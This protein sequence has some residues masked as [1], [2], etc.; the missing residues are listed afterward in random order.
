VDFSRAGIAQAVQD[1]HDF[2]FTT[3]QSTE[4]FRH[5]FPFYAVFLAHG[6]KLAADLH[7]VNP[8]FDYS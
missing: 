1:I 7:S 8:I 6:G 5:G 4:R 3:A 2:S